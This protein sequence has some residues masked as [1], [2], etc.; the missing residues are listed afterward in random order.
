MHF[1]SNLHL[2]PIFAFFHKWPSYIVFFFHSLAGAQTMN[3]RMTANRKGFNFEKV[4]YIREFSDE[5]DMENDDLP[6]NLLRL[7]E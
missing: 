4:V 2:C 1:L 3:M 7:V 6:P 5:E